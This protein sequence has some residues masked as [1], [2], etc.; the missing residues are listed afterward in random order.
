MEFEYHMHYQHV[1]FNPDLMLVWIEWHLTAT[2][3]GSEMLFM[4]VRSGCYKL[5]AR[6]DANI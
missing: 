5:N 4:A 1:S 6:T 2:S 3:N